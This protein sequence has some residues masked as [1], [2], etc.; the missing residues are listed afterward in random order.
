MI[1]DPAL[2]AYYN[3]ELSAIRETHSSSDDPHTARFIEAFALLHAKIHH[4]LDNDLPE[5]SK[6]LLQI[7]YPDYQAPIPSMGI[8][9][10]LTKNS[11]E[12]GLKIQSDPQHGALYTFRTCYS[13]TPSPIQ[14]SHACFSGT[15]LKIRF[16]PSETQKF[17]ERLRLYINAPYEYACQLYEWLMYRIERQP[18]VVPTPVG[19]EYD[20]NLLPNNPRIFAGYRLLKEFFNL[21]E[22]FLF[23]DLIDLKEAHVEFNFNKSN[24]ILEKY[25]CADWFALGCT[26]IINLF[27]LPLEPF[28]VTHTQTEYQLLP[29]RRYPKNVAEIYSIQRVMAIHAT[30][31]PLEYLPLYG[32]QTIASYDLAGYWH[33]NRKNHDVFLTLIN[34]SAANHVIHVDALCTNRHV[35]PRL[36]LPAGIRCLTPFTAAHV[37]SQTSDIQSRLLSHLTTNY[38]SLM[39]GEQGAAVLREVLK[40][41]GENQAQPIVDSL[42]RITHKPVVFCPSESIHPVY[43]EGTE[44]RLEVDEKKFNGSELFLFGCVLDH[45]FALSCA[46]NSFTQLTILS[47][48]HEK[49]YQWSPRFY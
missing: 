3:Q 46:M 11:Y 40:L 33:E 32:Q 27:S 6:T 41:Y 20:D 47:R 12:S 23:F 4:K 9:Q 8:V 18:H 19:F 7:L 43:Y 29:D 14:V 25:L 36:T 24:P 44:I 49:I 38:L 5:L 21:P 31:K 2:L 28:E 39:D 42:L 37:P 45:F 26:P 13:V 1:I 34:S 17:P 30:Q 16:T 35:P 48:E 15:S 10:F 22:K